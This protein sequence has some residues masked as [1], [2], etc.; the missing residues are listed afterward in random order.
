MGAV[1][2]SVKTGV[3]LG[4]KSCPETG[5]DLWQPIPNKNT[6]TRLD[7]TSCAKA[8]GNLTL[9]LYFLL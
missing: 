4:V 3:A 7:S 6:K 9:S 8:F 2:L 5:S 1:S